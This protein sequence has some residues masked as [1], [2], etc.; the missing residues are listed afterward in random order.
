MAKPELNLIS[1]PAS[2][3]SRL[4]DEP[5]TAEEKKT[6]TPDSEIEDAFNNAASSSGLRVPNQIAGRVPASS[7][8][9]GLVQGIDTHL[10]AGMR[11]ALFRGLKEV[12]LGFVESIYD[13]SGGDF[14]GPFGSAIALKYKEETFEAGDDY[15]REDEVR[16]ACDDRFKLDGRDVIWVES[17]GISEVGRGAKG[18]LPFGALADVNANFKL[19]GI[20]RYRRLEPF[21][22]ASGKLLRGQAFIN[23][24]N[25][26]IS[27]T[28]A[29]RMPPGGEFE[30]TGEGLIS[31]DPD[32]GKLLGYED[33]LAKVGAG[34]KA[35][36]KFEIKGETTVSVQ[37]LP[38]GEEVL[39]KIGYA[40]SA[41]ANVSAQ[42]DAGLK[43]KQ[44]GYDN[45]PELGRG[46]LKFLMDRM[47]IPDAR[48]FAKKYLKSQ[49]QLKS[50]YERRG[51]EIARFVFD[52]SK[53]GARQA[54]DDI[55]KKLSLGKTRTLVEAGDAAVRAQKAGEKVSISEKGFAATLGQ[56][57]LFLT[58]ALQAQREGKVSVDGRGSVIYR[59]C[60]FEKNYVNW[61]AGDQKIKWEVVTVDRAGKGDKQSYFHLGY[62]NR[63]RIT[64]EREIDE[65]L[66]FVRALGIKTKCADGASEKVAQVLA[67]R[68]DTE[69]KVNIYFTDQGIKNLSKKSESDCVQAFLDADRKMSGTKTQAKPELLQRF[70]EIAQMWF[71]V[72]LF[73]WGEMS[74]LREDYKNKAEGRSIDEDARLL[75]Q[76]KIFAEHITKLGSGDEKSTRRFFMELGQATGFEYMRT[77][78]ALTSL[79]SKE[80]SIIHQLSM[81]GGGL[82]LGAVDEGEI[83]HPDK[84][85]NR[86][87]TRIA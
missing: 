60:K 2:V 78:A 80:E 85:M 40:K 75:T 37:R 3:D 70:Q 6:K 34:A 38:F 68:D 61:V 9:F 44:D 7:G 65:F 22:S 18:T 79:V 53:P 29:R 50:R 5:A 31:F 87:L 86:M 36:A 27:A 20:V 39:V 49:I 28:L 54:Y 73:Y 81:S 1:K 63:D 16:R 66:R 8:A 30:I 71:F 23:A 41:N 4:F 25:A 14:E 43:V 47:E 84:A 74:R 15:I 26:P 19:S 56:T 58:S 32:I 77:I 62:R 10:G 17:E 64:E 55:F 24:M 33:D 12:G 42:L 48:A 82:T 35:G 59:D 69:T 83:L 57:K 13:N 51:S 52:L 46:A 72:R 45:L 11:V 76:A 21:E 67:D